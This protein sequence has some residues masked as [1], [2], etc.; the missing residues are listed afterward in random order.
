MDSN[1]SISSPP[2]SEQQEEEFHLNTSIREGG[3]S[4][5]DRYVFDESK[6]KSPLKIGS[7]SREQTTSLTA[8]NV[9]G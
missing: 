5:S 4:S 1:L 3:D 2:D 6:P 7:T 9:L 8:R